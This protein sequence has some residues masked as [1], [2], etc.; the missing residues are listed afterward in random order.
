LVV[1]EQRNA[2]LGWAERRRERKRL[3]QERAGDS[4]E[5]VA[6]RHTPR[7]DVVDF[8]LRLGGVERRSRFKP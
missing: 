3:E 4:P 1:G 2:R 7:G 5:K 8:M 6:Q